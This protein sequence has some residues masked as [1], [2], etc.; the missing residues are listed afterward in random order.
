MT[1]SECDQNYV[2]VNKKMLHAIVWYE[3]YMI[4]VTTVGP[5][6]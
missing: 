3:A 2:N 4:K 6:N 1:G 5:H